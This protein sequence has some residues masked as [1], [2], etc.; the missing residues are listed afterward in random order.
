MAPESRIKN[1]SRLKTV[2]PLLPETVLPL[3][4]MPRQGRLYVPRLRME[5]VRQEE[6]RAA[7][8]SFGS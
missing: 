5:E 2:L 3:L 8:P 6:F 1:G 4:R 7:Q